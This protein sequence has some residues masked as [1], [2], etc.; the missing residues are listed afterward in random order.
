MHKKL[1][2]STISH[3]SLNL[4]PKDEFSESFLG[5]CLTWS[6][7]IG[8]YLVILTELIVILSFISRF[9]L[10]RDLTDLNEQI[11]LQKQIILS[12]ADTEQQFRTIQ[13]KVD[14]INQTQET[15]LIIETLTT[16]ERLV[17][18]GVKI[19]QL[20]LRPTAITFSGSAF[21]PQLVKRVTDSLT[22]HYNQ[23]QITLS[24]VK[25]NSQTGN[26]DFAIRI[27]QVSTAKKT[28]QASRANQTQE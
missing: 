21:S 28:A 8:R 13:A 24:E 9:K 22:V 19:A 2:K 1:P 18:P 23:Q 20:S 3:I 26:V 16:L 11:N 14:H 12:Y 10:D 15:D 27:N 25:L 17:P 6:L 7:S 4:L 5:K